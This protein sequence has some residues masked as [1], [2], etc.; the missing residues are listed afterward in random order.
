MFLF[1]IPTLVEELRSIHITQFIFHSKQL[2]IFKMEKLEGKSITLW[3]SPTLRGVIE[4]KISNPIPLQ[5]TSSSV[6]EQKRGKK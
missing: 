1:S 6:I 3:S 2:P 4:E 5:I